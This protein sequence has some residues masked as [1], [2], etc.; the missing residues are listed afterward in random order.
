MLYKVGGIVV[1]RKT[2]N[3]TGRYYMIDSQGVEHDGYWNTY[4]DEMIDKY[5]GNY[6]KIW[7][8]ESGYYEVETLDG[9]PTDFIWTDEMFEG[10]AGSFCLGS[11]I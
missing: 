9:V 1:P 6:V 4:T 11:L 7:S 3:K 5:G 10:K 8:C 2:K